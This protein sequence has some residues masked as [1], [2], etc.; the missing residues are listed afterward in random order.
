MKTT[1]GSSDKEKVHEVPG[2]NSITVGSEHF[3]CPDVLTNVQ[4]AT[5]DVNL[6]I[7][8]RSRPLRCCMRP[9][10]EV[11]HVEGVV[12]MHCDSGFNRRFPWR[13]R[14]ISGSFGSRISD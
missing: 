10:G 5:T 9:E 11:R 1:S 12:Y 4:N 3:R 7:V 6:F 13:T 8:D 14:L 2:G